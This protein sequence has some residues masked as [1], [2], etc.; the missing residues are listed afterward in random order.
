MNITERIEIVKQIE[1]I[2]AKTLET[3]IKVHSFGS[4]RYQLAH[5]NPDI[6][7]PIDIESDIDLLVV[8]ENTCELTDV[9]KKMENIEEF[10]QKVII[11]EAFV[12]LFTFYYKKVSID[13]LFALVPNINNYDTRLELLDEKTVF[14]LNGYRTTEKICSMVPNMHNFRYLLQNVKDWARKTGIYSNKLC[15]LGGISWAILTA[16]ICIKYPNLRE[17]ELLYKFFE[18]FSN[19]N[20]KNPVMLCPMIE[21][22]QGHKSWNGHIAS[23]SH[24]SL[25]IVTPVYPHIN[26]SYQVNKGSAFLIKHYLRSTW[27]NIQMKEEVSCEVFNE[28]DYV[29]TFPRK[30]GET[31]EH[32]F[33]NL[34]VQIERIYCVRHVMITKDDVYYKFNIVIEKNNTEPINLMEPIQNWVLQTKVELSDKFKLFSTI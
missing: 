16:F 33:R 4:F 7:G 11:D 20:W 2:L 26:T 32:T 14:S 8:M 28:F 27:E 19:W 10:E 31:I 6:D 23:N 9:L 24:H 1:K 17:K 29:L 21:T 13:L 25:K 5:Y 34:V 12:P 15:Y 18:I 22:L 30:D 3:V